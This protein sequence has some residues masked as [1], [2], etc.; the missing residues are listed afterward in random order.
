MKEAVG[1]SMVLNIILIFVGIFIALYV[2]TIAYSKG[3]KVRNRIIDII[4]KYD[5]YTSSAQKEIDENLKMVGYQINLSKKCG[6]IDNPE[7]PSNHAQSLSNNSS[8]NY[9]VYEFHTSKGYY[10]GVRVFIHFDFPIIGSFIEIPLYGESRILFE[11]S[12]VEG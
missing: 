10:Y 7:D 4:E 1:T 11:K 12:E 2:G 5:G 3:F 9:C 6:D 8:Y